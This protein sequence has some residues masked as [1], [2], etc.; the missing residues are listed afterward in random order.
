MRKLLIAPLVTATLLIALIVTGERVGTYDVNRVFHCSH[1]VTLAPLPPADILF[2]GNSQ[3]GAGID[4]LYFAKQLN[5]LNPPRVEKLTIVEAH[6]VTLRMLAEDY[7]EQRGAPKIVIFQPMVV[8]NTSWQ[9]AAGKPIHP[10][11]NLA[12]QPWDEL[13]HVQQAAKQSPNTAL[14][15]T[16]MQKGY[17]TLPA[18]FV[19]RLVERIIASMSY[20]RLSPMLNYCQSEQ[21]FRQSIIWP[22]GDLPLESSGNTL[23]KPDKNRA[24]TWAERV[25]SRAPFLSDDP[26]RVFELEQNLELIREFEEAGSKVVLVGYPNFEAA[27]QDSQDFATFSNA[28]GSEVHDIRAL[29][30]S[31]ERDSLPT[32]FR[33]QF[34]LSFAGAEIV[35]KRLAHFLAKISP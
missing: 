12:I 11:A 8:R 3:T 4:P 31:A 5:P 26:H 27:A 17:R 10:R 22:Y 19:D 6:I 9:E 15:P 21:M 14:V 1:A 23:T 34:H 16:W 33:D 28:L 35:S 7:I 24:V 20:F 25:K 2:V 29:L 18:V 13:V 30:S 32:L